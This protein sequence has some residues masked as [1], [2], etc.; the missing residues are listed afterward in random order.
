MRVRHDLSTERR[1]RQRRSLL[2]SSTYRREVSYN[3]VFIQASFVSLS[4]HLFFHRIS[5]CFSLCSVCV[6]SGSYFCMTNQ[7]MC[8]SLGQLNSVMFDLFWI[9]VF[10]CVWE[11]KSVNC[12]QVDKYHVQEPFRTFNCRCFHSCFSQIAFFLSLFRC[13]VVHYSVIN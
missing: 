2:L 6:V 8:V 1:E 5:L 13:F 4:I 12:F 7:C 10:E 11:R 9:H 3:S